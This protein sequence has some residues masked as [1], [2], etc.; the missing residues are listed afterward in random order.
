MLPGPPFHQ[1][2]FRCSEYGKG[3]L[4]RRS[5]RE[6]GNEGG[7]GGLRDWKGKR[8]GRNG[9]GDGVRHGPLPI[10][11]SSKTQ[12]F[13]HQANNFVLFPTPSC[14]SPSRHPP[15]PL[16]LS[17]ISFS[18]TL[19]H[20]SSSFQLQFPHEHKDRHRQTQMNT[21]TH[22][23]FFWLRESLALSLSQSL[24]QSA[25]QSTVFFLRSIASFRGAHLLQP[26]RIPF[27]HSHRRQAGT[28]TYCLK[29]KTF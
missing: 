15:S 2:H 13:R 1:C 9:Y 11:C 20:S 4:K 8:S 5:D 22:A 17:L 6:K 24:S 14:A 10:L 19:A 3:K 7:R 16:A 28:S 29:L 12:T 23:L 18:L 21:H 26:R 27:A 25:S